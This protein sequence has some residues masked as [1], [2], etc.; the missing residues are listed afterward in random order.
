MRP[1]LN[2]HARH[3]W[4]LPQADAAPSQPLGRPGMLCVAST[5]ERSVLEVEM[6][7][8]GAERPF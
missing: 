1:T 4:A 3:C 6:R 5:H 8:V 2:F 7:G